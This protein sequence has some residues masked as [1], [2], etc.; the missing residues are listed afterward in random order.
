MC[1][2]GYGYRFV[3]NKKIINDKKEKVLFYVGIIY[4][5]DF[6]LRCL[7][8]VIVRIRVSWSFLWCICLVFNCFKGDGLGGI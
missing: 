1:F 7:F 2:F 4:L 8:L 6:K 5:V 3:Y